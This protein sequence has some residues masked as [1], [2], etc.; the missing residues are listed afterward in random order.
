MTKQEREDFMGGSTAVLVAENRRLPVRMQYELPQIWLARGADR[1]VL[2]DTVCRN[3]HYTF[4]LV[5][6][7]RQE[8]RDVQLTLTDAQGRTLDA[9]TATCFNL[10][11]RDLDGREQIIHRDVKPGGVLPLWCG[12]KLENLTDTTVRL[13]AKVSAQGLAEPLEAEIVLHVE[14]KTLPNNGDDDLWRMSRLFWLNSDI[15]ISDE[16]IAPY[17]PVSGTQQDGVLDINGKRIRVGDLG[18]PEQ[19]DS[20]YD[21]EVRLTDRTQVQLLKAPMNLEVTQDGAVCA[22]ENTQQNWIYRGTQRTTVKTCQQRGGI[23][24][25]SEAD[26]EADG[27]L[28]VHITVEARQDGEYAFSL[29]LPLAEKAVPYM[30]GM[31]Y[32]GGSTPMWWEYKWDPGRFGNLVWLGGV[33]AGVQLKLMPEEEAWVVGGNANRLPVLWHNDGKGSLTVKKQPHDDCVTVQARTGTVAMKA[34]QREMLHFHLLLTPFHPIDYRHHWNEHIYHVDNWD[35]ERVPDLEKAK[36]HGATMINLHQGGMLNEN[37]NYPFILAP[38]LKEHVAQAHEMGLRYKLYYTVREL[39]N[40]TAEL[41]AL[42]SLG[43]EVFRSDA[44]QMVLADQFASEEDKK[45]AQA[46]VNGKHGGPWLHEHLVEGFMGAWHQ[47]LYDGEYDC[48]VATQHVSRWHNYY[49]KG[50]EWLIREVGVDGLY[51]DGIGYDRRVMKRLRRVLNASGKKCD[52]DI[53]SGNEH[54]PAYGYSAPANKYLEH[55][56]YADSLWLGEGYMYEEVCPDYYL[57]ESSGIPFGL[58]GEMLHGG[59]NPWRGM[60]YGMT[61]RLGWQQGGISDVVW[62]VWNDFGIT[63]ARM[64]GYWH[65][66]CPVTTE[67][68]QVRATAYVRDDGGILVAVASWYPRDRSYIVQL[69][70]EQLGLENGYELYAPAIAGVQEERVFDDSALIPIQ[71]NRGWIFVVRRK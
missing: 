40:Y 60:V 53:H 9:E 37:I 15:G 51:L 2:E 47:F 11:G 31:C 68:D 26:Y 46:A 36:A 12:V 27:H 66:D 71:K 5:L 3:E 13:R 33:R 45:A 21:D 61:A 34:G 1:T 29:T 49:L 55:F 54:E 6:C 14:E 57:V 22:A 48:A 30:M 56:A 58:M 18:L 44:D 64:L 17:Q 20:L 67:S 10:C 69:N 19:I 43:D 50:M 39:S 35:E 52:M 25:E 32:E 42:R 63:D 70:R 62:K 23:S 28:D 7:A 59:G 38:K 8:L 41:W 65:P 24:L 16:V 4:Q